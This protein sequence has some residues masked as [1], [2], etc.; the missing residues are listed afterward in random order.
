VPPNVQPNRL[1]I[2]TDG[3]GDGGRLLLLVA[4]DEADGIRT[5]EGRKHR[6]LDKHIEVWRGPVND[7]GYSGSFPFSVS[8][9]VALKVLRSPP[10]IMILGTRNGDPD[11]NR[12]CNGIC[13]GKEKGGTTYR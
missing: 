9:E 13:D 1:I 12:F 8:I 4:E 6:R 2:D 3:G 11:C 10:R 7:Q 5:R